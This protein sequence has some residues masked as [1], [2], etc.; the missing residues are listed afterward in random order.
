VQQAETLLTL[1]ERD[2]EIAR[3]Q[4]QLEEMPEKAAILELRHKIKNV[5]HLSEKARRFIEQANAVL[6]RL[7]DESS[8]IEAHFQTEQTKATSGETS[9]HKE[10]QNLARELESLRKQKDR[11]DTEVLTQMETVEAGEARAAQ[12]EAGLAKARAREAQLI[13]GFQERGG[14]I[15]QRLDA[16]SRERAAMAALLRPSLLE[17]Y[18]QTRT[19]KHGIGVGVLE[20]S[21]CSV[22]RIELPAE[23]AQALREDAHRTSDPVGTCPNCHRILIVREAGL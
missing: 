3:L 10:L 20:G 1:S 18:E 16:L 6:R 7:E 8:A 22:C 19:L 23:R 14:S 4:K 11:K 9:N 17:R 2:L 21:T 12:I 5:E 13:A 15:Q